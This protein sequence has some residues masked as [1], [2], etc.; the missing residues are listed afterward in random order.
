VTVCA[1]CCTAVSAVDGQCDGVVRCQCC[2]ARAGLA[3]AGSQ[4]NHHCWR[5]AG[6]SG[7]MFE[8]CWHR[9]AVSR[10]QGPVPCAQNRSNRAD[11]RGLQHTHCDLRAPTHIFRCSIHRSTR[12]QAL[13]GLGLRHAAH[14]R[15]T[16]KPAETRQNADRD[17][18][19]Q[20]AALGTGPTPPK[21]MSPAW[22]M[23]SHTQMVEGAP[24]DLVVPLQ[25]LGKTARNGNVMLSP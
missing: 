10:L 1:Q 17:R 15:R 6:G 12:M 19:R 5:Q 4:Y 21:L 18:L 16:R 14:S 2:S 23:T 3:T 7:H 9:T 24:G 22:T 11:A 13:A 25:P 20:G 8:P